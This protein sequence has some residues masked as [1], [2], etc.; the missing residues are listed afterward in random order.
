MPKKTGAAADGKTVIILEATP[1]QKSTGR[2]AWMQLFA[3]PTRK[4]VNLAFQGEFGAVGA[5]GNCN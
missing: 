1:T 2:N 3:N 4:R 5:K